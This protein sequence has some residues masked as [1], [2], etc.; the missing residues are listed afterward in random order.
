MN[1]IFTICNWHNTMNIKSVLWMLVT[2]Y[3]NTRASVDTELNMHHFFPVSQL[4]KMKEW[5][6]CFHPV[7]IN[8]LTNNDSEKSD[9]YSSLLV[10]LLAPG[11]R[12]NFKSINLGQRLWI[13]FMIIH[14]WMPQNTTDDK[15]TLVQVI[16]WY[17][18]ATSNY[19]SQHWPRSQSPWHH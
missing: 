18:L 11:W 19:L 16:A 13:R 14:S 1:V 5:S 10:N 3:I 4:N 17:Q 15:S 9:K 12:I 7:S 8:S 6:M 2:W